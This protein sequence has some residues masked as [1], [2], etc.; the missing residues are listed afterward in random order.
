MDAKQAASG[1]GLDAHYQKAVN[2]IGE[3]HVCN[4]GC[5]EGWCSR[6][7]DAHQQQLLALV[8]KSSIESSFHAPN[9]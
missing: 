4:Q 1:L 2:E 8:R 5:G 7:E 9:A 6:N 3:S